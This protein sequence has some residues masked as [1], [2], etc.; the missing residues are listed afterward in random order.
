MKIVSILAV[1]LLLM[2]V[3]GA[4]ERGL[5]SLPGPHPP[6]AGEVQSAPSVIVTPWLAVPAASDSSSLKGESRAERERSP[7]ES[8]TVNESH[9]SRDTITARAI[10]L[11]ISDLPAAIAWV[12]QLADD[13]DRRSALL[14]VAYETA[15]MKPITALTLALE[16]PSGRA[17]D[18]L[19]THAA[20]EWAA[21]DPQAASEWAK[22]ISENSLRDH[23]LAVVATAWGESDPVAAA[24]L[25]VSSLPA[26]RSQEDALIGILQRWV[27]NE[28]TAAAAWV[29]RF[30][31]GELRQTAVETLAQLWP[32]ELPVENAP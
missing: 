19:I 29:E 13:E 20:A 15:R 24:N 27:Q 26:G 32:S 5:P 25:A 12:Q 9:A 31:I 23:V 28:P 22:Q 18:D 8:Q 2:L 1:A 4:A 17:R 21:N 10:E 11:A 6:G 7:L 3:L 30:P 16:L 14:H